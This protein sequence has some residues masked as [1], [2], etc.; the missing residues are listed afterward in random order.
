MTTAATLI[1]WAWCST[2]VNR[3]NPNLYVIEHFIHY[4]RPPRILFHALLSY[5]L[6][7]TYLQLLPHAAHSYPLYH[8]QG[9]LR[10]LTTILRSHYLLFLV[11]LLTLVSIPLVLPF[12]ALHRSPDPQRTQ[13]PQPLLVIGLDKVFHLVEVVF[14]LVR[15]AGVFFGVI[16]AIV[17]VRELLLL[18]FLLLEKD[19]SLLLDLVR[20]RCQIGRNR[21]ETCYWWGLLLRLIIHNYDNND[22]KQ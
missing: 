9:L 7:L 17:F 20:R 4:L 10:L 5:Q 18:I 14:I 21:V 12:Q 1:W 2:R 15:R 6:S 19:G 8:L 11:F 16:A 3:N 13:L 22:N